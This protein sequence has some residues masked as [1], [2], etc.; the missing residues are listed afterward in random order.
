MYI[1]KRGG[2]RGEERK[3]QKKGRF[4]LIKYL[5]AYFLSR[6]YAGKYKYI[7]N[8]KAYA[9]WFSFYICSSFPNREKDDPLDVSYP[10]TP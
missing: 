1:E 2:G 9:L 7:F 4:V 8:L 10:L 3:R 6:I 5:Y